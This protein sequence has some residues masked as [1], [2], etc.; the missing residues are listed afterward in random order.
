MAISKIKHLFQQQK[1]S[2]QDNGTA[3]LW[4]QYMD[5]VDNVRK[6]IKAERTVYSF[7]QTSKRSLASKKKDL[8][9][10]CQVHRMSFLNGD[11]KS[12]NVKTEKR[13]VCCHMVKHFF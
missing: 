1:E 9:I 10:K 7:Y 13:H 3:K 11:P 5:M 6:S 12:A 4:L 2:L 8:T